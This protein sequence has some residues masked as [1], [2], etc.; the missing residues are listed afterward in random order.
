M[1]RA[2]LRVFRFRRFDYRICILKNPTV[3]L[4]A[5]EA[6]NN[7]HFFLAK[8]VFLLVDFK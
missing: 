4:S 1:P 8:Y 5:I 3:I 7:F 6:K 2:L